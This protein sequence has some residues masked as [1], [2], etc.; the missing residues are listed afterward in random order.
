MT[1]NL[2]EEAFRPRD[3]WRLRLLTEDSRAEPFL[4]TDLEFERELVASNL[5]AFLRVLII[6]QSRRLTIRISTRHKRSCKR[7]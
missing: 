5:D 1:F 2:D 6:R 7:S 3:P 4:P